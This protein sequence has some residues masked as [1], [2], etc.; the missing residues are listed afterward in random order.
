MKTVFHASFRSVSF[1]AHC[2]AHPCLSGYSQP[3]VDEIAKVYHELERR[4][5]LRQVG[6]LG[7]KGSSQIGQRS[8]I[9]T[10][11]PSHP[12]SHDTDNIIINKSYIIPTTCKLFSSICVRWNAD[13]ETNR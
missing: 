11:E 12:Q 7:Q 6:R 4:F 1:M 2:S 9:R 3:Q 10:Y 8:G 5:N 13:T